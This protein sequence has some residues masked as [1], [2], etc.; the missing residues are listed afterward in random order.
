M[1]VPAAFQEDDLG[2]LH[3]LIE[4][5]RLGTL[6]TAGLSLP[7]ATSLRIVGSHIPFMLDRARGPNGTLVGHVDRRNTQW[8]TL[9]EGG[10]ALVTFLGPDAHVSAA[11]YGTKPRVPTWLYAAVH[12]YG[13]AT[14]V[15]DASVLRDM[16]VELSTLM[17]PAGT[18]WSPS[19][20]DSYI[21]RLMRSIVG[22]EIPID[23][24]EGQVRLAQHNTADD[25]RR[26]RAA[27]ASGGPRQQRVAA[28]M[29]RLFGS[30]G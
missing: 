18:T 7:A 26:V 27:L 1:F 24:I 22:F 30:A 17:E 3:A 8:Q 12:C 23:R 2:T 16:V 19:Q 5:A 21:D 14:M 10:E 9:A 15:T 28:L 20:V 6:L 13:R 4:D 29:D 25:R 11:W